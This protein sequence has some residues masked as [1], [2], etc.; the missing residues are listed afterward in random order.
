MNSDTQTTINTVLQIVLLILGL[1][2]S[3]HASRKLYQSKQRVEKRRKERRHRRQVNSTLNF[4]TQKNETVDGR[5]KTLME[6]LDTLLKAQNIE[7]S[8][9]TGDIENQNEE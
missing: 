7:H 8:S 6:W 9:S 4:L 1:I 5:T 2:T 3:F